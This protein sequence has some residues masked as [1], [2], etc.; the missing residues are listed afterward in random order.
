MKNIFSGMLIT[1]ALVLVTVL[2]VAALAE[3]VSPEV[4]DLPAVESAPEASDA[5][6]DAAAGTDSAAL[7]DALNAYN[8][9][10]QSSRMESIEAELKDFVASGKLTQAQADL[11]LNYYKERD[12]LRN[13]TCPN[14]GYEFQNGGGFGRGGRMNGGKGGRGGRGMR[15]FGQQYA[16][17]T[18]SGAQPNGGTLDGTAYS[19]EWGEWSFQQ[20]DD[21]LEGI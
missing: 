14:C 15:G 12:A 11:I 19:Q 7:Q 6:S 17:N 20:E 2:G 1:L 18:Q 21:S 16:D 10:R 13:G 9:A 5:Q 8:Q 3:T 4:P